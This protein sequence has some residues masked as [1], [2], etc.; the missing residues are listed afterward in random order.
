MCQLVEREMKP[1]H[2]LTTYLLT[3]KALYS[4]SHCDPDLPHLFTTM[5][6]RCGILFI[7]GY[8]DLQKLVSADG[9]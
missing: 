4:I 5:I 1:V 8:F 6:V 3:Q 7:D 2:C 9:R